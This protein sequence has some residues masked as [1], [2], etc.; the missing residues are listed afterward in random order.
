M[1]TEILVKVS[2]R[3]FINNIV[4]NE[5]KD[6]LF[7]HIIAKYFTICI[8]RMEDLYVDLTTNRYPCRFSKIAK[9][10]H[11]CYGFVCDLGSHH[12]IDFDENSSH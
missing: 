1:V 6:V 10:M 5:A 3:H 2:D 9:E 12:A 11:V 8:Y 4:F 7:N